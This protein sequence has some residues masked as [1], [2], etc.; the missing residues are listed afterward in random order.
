MKK[1]FT[2]FGIVLFFGHL[3]D[4][5]ISSGLDS[6]TKGFVLLMGL[7][8]VAYIIASPKNA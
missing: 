5:A 7:F 6:S 4:Y 3:M 2:V 8:S 1:A